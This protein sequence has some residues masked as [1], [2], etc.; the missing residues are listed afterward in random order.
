MVALP[1]SELEVVIARKPC[2]VGFPANPKTLGDYLRRRRIELGLL[3]RDVAKI[4]GVS[5]D[6]ITFWE[7]NKTD[8][9]AKHVAKIIHFIGELPPILPN[10]FA[11][12]IKAYRYAH[13]L[14]HAQMGE[15]VGVNASTI[16]A[17]EAGYIPNLENEL[18]LKKLL[19]TI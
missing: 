5:E 9:T 17:W 4:V 16:G 11:G 8:P 18:V 3:Q 14:T 19:E 10:T 6:C 2:G 13:G 1:F 12:K 15:L 7:N